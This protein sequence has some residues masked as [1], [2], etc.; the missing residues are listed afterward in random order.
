MLTLNVF[1]L[2]NFVHISI[3]NNRKNIGVL[4]SLGVGNSDVKKIFTFEA[5]IIYIVS[6]ALS[7]PLIAFV[8]HIAN[9]VYADNLIERT[10]DI[11]MWNL[12]VF[13]VVLLVEFIANYVI[14]KLLMKRFHRM[15][16]MDLIR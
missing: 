12:N 5:W 11:V 1:M 9:D 8:Q 15:K 6:F 3:R 7:I 2:S 10:Y 13:G 4:R 14:L 16:I